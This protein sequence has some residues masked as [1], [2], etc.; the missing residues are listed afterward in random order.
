MNYTTIQNNK[1]KVIAQGVIE[2][3]LFV[4]NVTNRPEYM[5]PVVKLDD[6]VRIRNIFNNNIWK[7]V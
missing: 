1:T 5:F 3:D 6:N 7:I 4:G 2:N